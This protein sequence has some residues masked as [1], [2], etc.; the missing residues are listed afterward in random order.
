[1]RD[2][3]LRAVA[4]V[5]AVTAAASVLLP[6]GHPWGAVGVLAVAALAD[7]VLLRD[8]AP[9]YRT[10]EVLDRAA[11]RPVRLALRGL[12][13]VA[14]G[15]ALWSTAVGAVVAVALAGL[16][17]LSG[18]VGA[19]DWALQGLRRH[20]VA[21]GIAGL[22]P[23]HVPRPRP[24]LL[25]TVPEILVAG[26]AL[27]LPTR[28]VLVALAAVL[29][30]GVTVTTAVPWL[31][32]VRRVRA[33]RV[34]RLRAAQAYLD[35]VA[36]EVVL[37]FG[38]SEKTVHEVA[39]W[40]P[41]LEG[42]PSKAL[43]LV[44]N[45][46]AFEAL[47]STTSAVLCVPAAQD[48]MTLRL[49]C[50]RVALFVSNIGNNIHLLRHPGIRTAFIG[51]GDSDKSASVNPF[52]KVY[53]EIW[54][55]G[56]AGRER[57]DRAGVGVRPGAFVEVGRPQLEL[58][59]PADDTRPAVPTV[60]YAPTWEGWNAEQ[61]Y[62]SVT[63]HGE[64]LVRA[65]LDHPN[66]IRLLYRPHPY[67]GRRSPA[68]AAAHRRIVAL[69]DEANARAG[70]SASLPDVPVPPAVRTRSARER[71]AYDV[72]AGEKLLRGLPPRAHVAIGAQDVPLIS[73]FN[74]SDGMVTDVSSVLTDFL[75]RDKPIAV[76]DPLARGVAV[77]TAQFPTAAAG[78]VMAPGAQGFREWLAM[79]SAGVSDP[80]AEARARMRR[81]LLGPDDPP[82]S[83]RF[84]DAV[85]R[86]SLSVH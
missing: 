84:A 72:G 31:V 70:L 53:D 78:F 86:Q 64:H 81:H 19:L 62:C 14:A 6:V 48:L 69:I 83:R 59:R 29:A 75:A 49:D 7:A 45:R 4:A 82:P 17:L 65:V 3:Y 76:C 18:A 51:H 47:P 55:A 50:L 8:R 27:A 5:L 30:L 46:A 15:A 10:T 9:G 43:V 13:L 77:F 34:P 44:R 35:E 56:P 25:V 79:L 60:L 61:D 57:Y 58:V 22:A 40:L 74:L 68:V 16:V 23:R 21:R 1:V 11:G 52:S 12:V 28:A 71:H 24:V 38:D 80:A 36:P 32:T 33:E 67:T 42:L 63:T 85:A 37:Y 20:P 73:C 2:P 66:P 39:M 54:V 41:A 26:A